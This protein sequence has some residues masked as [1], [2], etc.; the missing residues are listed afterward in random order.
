MVL[1]VIA[2]GFVSMKSCDSAVSLK[3]EQTLMRKEKL[4]QKVQE[5]EDIARERLEQALEPSQ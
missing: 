2:I 4:Q 3:T 5:S 1:A